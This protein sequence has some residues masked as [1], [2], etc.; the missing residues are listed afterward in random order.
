MVKIISTFTGNSD[1]ADTMSRLGQSLWGNNLEREL[2]SEKLYAMQRDNRE[3]DN[4]MK[5]VAAKKAQEL[6]NSPL[7]QA[8]IIGA[9]YDPAKFAELGRMGA[10]TE[11]GA[12]DPRTANWQ[13]AAGDPYSATQP[14]FAQTLAETT[15]AHNLESG[16]RRYNVDQNVGFK[17]Y[18]HDNISAADQ[19]Q[20]ADRRYSVDQSQETLRTK[21]IAGFD[22]NTG[23]PVF[24]PSD[25]AMSIQPLTT[26]SQQKS[27]LLDKNWAD[28]AGLSPEQRQVLG[29]NLPANSRALTPRNYI[30][31]GGKT[32]LTYDGRTDVNGNP[33]P[34]GGYIG[35]V[36]GSA[37]DTGVTNAVKTGLQNNSIEV[38]KFDVLASRAMELTKHPELFGAQGLARYYGQEALQGAKGMLSIFGDAKATQAMLDEARADAAAAG[39]DPNT[40]PALYD[41]RL[42]QVSQDWALLT[43]QMA[44]A[45]AAQTG[46]KLSDKDVK[47]F[48]RI[49]GDPHSIFTSQQ[50]MQTRLQNAIDIVHGYDK[51]NQEALGKTPTETTIVPPRAEVEKKPVAD[52]PVMKTPTG[53]PFRIL[54]DGNP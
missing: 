18:A 5:L 3:T 36:Q 45:A 47:F 33:L 41:R 23:Q 26:E 42:P 46:S 48:T 21:P 6:G 8:M 25:Q 52:T 44:A 12:S 50:D 40:L 11:Y 28:L 34:P 7:A 39:I 20:S 9:G 35:T 53:I 1:L 54:P 4:L 30:M 17:R 14:A 10:A 29:A 49:M 22:P 38:K 51:V 16:D 19:Q 37:T 31:P 32:V 27:I 13:I 24:V 15:R 43:Y 2:N